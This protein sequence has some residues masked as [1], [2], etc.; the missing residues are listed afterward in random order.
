MSVIIQGTQL[1]QIA[2]G[3]LAEKASGAISSDPT[4][5]LFTIAGGEV[6]VTGFYLKVTTA[7][8]TNGGT[9]ALQAN[10]TTGDTTTIVAA[11]DLGTT[12][13]AVGTTIGVSGFIADPATTGATFTRVFT[14]GGALLRDIPVTTGALELVGASSVNGAVTA[15]CTWIPLTTGATLVA[16]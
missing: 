2:L 11:T 12:D 13:S 15:Y 4:I 3:Q 8:T 16:S 7:I 10:P 9:L 14:K 6:L 1:R 5:S